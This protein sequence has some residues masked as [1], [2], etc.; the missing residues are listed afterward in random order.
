LISAL[1]GLSVHGWIKISSE[2]LGKLAYVYSNWVKYS[3]LVLYSRCS[4][5][6]YILLSL[7]LTKHHTMKLYLLLN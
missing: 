4:S 2:C 5:F 3:D 7:Y 6:V 1:N